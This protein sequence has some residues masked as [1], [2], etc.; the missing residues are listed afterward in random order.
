MCDDKIEAFWLGVPFLELHES[1]RSRMLNR[2]SH[3]EALKPR[4]SQKEAKSPAIFCL[5]GGQDFGKR[6]FEVPW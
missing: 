5:K 2:T 3:R 1:K 6:I 4:M